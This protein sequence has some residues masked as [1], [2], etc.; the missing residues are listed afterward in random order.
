MNSYQFEHIHVKYAK[1]MISHKGRLFIK[2]GSHIYLESLS[3]YSCLETG[4]T[5]VFGNNG[6]YVKRISNY[7]TGI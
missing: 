6:K 1:V 2:A 5:Y 7:T 3:D 4:L